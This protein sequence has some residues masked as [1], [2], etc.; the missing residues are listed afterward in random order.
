MNDLSFSGLLDRHR[1]RIHLGD[2][3]RMGMRRGHSGGWIEVIVI[4]SR[5]DSDPVLAMDPKTHE[6]EQMQWDQELRELVT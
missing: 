2:L 1:K 5:N 6:V 3:I 4:R